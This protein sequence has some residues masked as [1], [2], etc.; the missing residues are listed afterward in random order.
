MHA[1]VA[2]RSWGGVPPVALTGEL[3]I[4]SHEVAALLAV[5]RR[6]IGEATACMKSLDRAQAS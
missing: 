6:A 2:E 5:M 4:V 3:A 1:Q